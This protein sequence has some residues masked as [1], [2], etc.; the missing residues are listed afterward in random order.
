MVARLREVLTAGGP[1]ARVTDAMIE[2]PKVSVVLPVF[3]AAGQVT[4][5]VERLAEQT[6]TDLEVIVVDDG[7]TDGT[8]AELEAAVARW[9]HMRL[10]ALDPNQGVARARDRGL[11]EARGE[12]V[13]F[14]DW[15]DGWSTDFLARMHAACVAADADVVVCAAERIDPDGRPGR[16]I[17]CGDAC[18]LTGEGGY[19]A[20]LLRGDVQGFLW[21]KLF[22]RSLLTP[23]DFPPLASQEDMARQ[24]LLAERVRRFTR[25]PDVLYTHVER[26]G[27]IVNSTPRPANLVR[28]VQVADAVRPPGP[29]WHTPAAQR[30]YD[31]FFVWFAAVAATNTA[32]R[33]GTTDGES[34]AVLDD[35]RRRLDGRKLHAAWDFSPSVALQAAAI[36][37]CPG[38]YARAYRLRRRARRRASR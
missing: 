18:T 10:L 13:W 27:S 25:I 19:L 16:P 11:R 31:W 28:C 33:S 2:K 6:F 14:V 17:E 1:A 38:A 15:D 20:A 8:R 36:R 7:S 26:P 4:D 3:N 12:Y 37:W 23:A 34:A 35:L 30:L 24:L 29:D 22:R 9:P 32:L 21:N 5:A